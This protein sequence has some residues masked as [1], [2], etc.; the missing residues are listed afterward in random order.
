MRQVSGLSRRPSGTSLGV[1]GRTKLIG[2]TSRSKY[3]FWA[4]QGLG[5]RAAE[6]LG[7]TQKLNFFRHS[8]KS[9][10]GGLAKGVGVS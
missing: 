9:P 8:E 10:D 2:G 5:T 7:P 6:R 3:R 1:A 4:P